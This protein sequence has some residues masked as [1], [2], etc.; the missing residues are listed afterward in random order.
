VTP[1]QRIGRR[2]EWSKRALDIAVASIGLLILLPL[3]C[4]IACVIVADSGRPFLYCPV[5]VG[6]YGRPFTMY[7][8][9]S[10]VVDAISAGGLM[11]GTHDPRVTKVGAVLRAYKL[12]ELPQL[13]NV[14]KGEMS[15]VGPRPEHPEYTELYSDEEQIALEA[16]PGLTDLASIE[17][18]AVPGLTDLASIE[19]IR[20]ND[21]LGD[22]D[23]SGFY[24]RNVAPVKNQLRIKYVRERSF[25]GDVK[26][27]VLTICRIA[28][29]DLKRATRGRTGR[30]A[31]VVAPPDASG[32]RL[33]GSGPSSIQVDAL[34]SDPRMGVLSED[35]L[36]SSRGEGRA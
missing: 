12:D 21:L 20:L 33:R 7:K 29:Y 13:L 35:A 22:D 15:L 4:V 34:L 31:L 18:E 32:G 36:P 30:A 10:M 3:L 6:R 19:L 2:Y 5:R 9:R 14:L 25:W 11:T 23:P 27:I 16:V 17:L 24:L 1:D 28:T 26:I 8:F